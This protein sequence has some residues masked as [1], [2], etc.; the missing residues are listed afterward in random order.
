MRKHDTVGRCQ[1][2]EGHYSPCRRYVGDG[3]VGLCAVTVKR[4][5]G[6]CA[7]ESGATVVGTE[8]SLTE[9]TV[10]SS[11]PAGAEDVLFVQTGGA[12]IGQIA[13]RKV[14]INP[15]YNQSRLRQ[16]GIKAFLFAVFNHKIFAMAD[17]LNLISYVLVGV[18]ADGIKRIRA[19]SRDRRYRVEPMTVTPFGIGS[20]VLCDGLYVRH[21]V[22]HTHR[23][24]S[25]LGVMVKIV[26]T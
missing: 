19:G 18:T 25:I 1:Q 26:G 11:C 6:C 15:V 16:T 5:L 12:V 21:Q 13:A 10:R 22:P 17:R 23:I 14:G 4:T 9:I 7:S 20:H 24:K 8:R 2:I 3:K